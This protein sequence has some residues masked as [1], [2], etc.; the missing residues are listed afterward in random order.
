MSR[1]IK[2]I[3]QIK[4]EVAWGGLETQTVSKDSLENFLLLFTLLTGPI[5]KNSH[6]LARIYFIFLKKVS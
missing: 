6:I 5:V 3:K 1:I 2:I 4:S